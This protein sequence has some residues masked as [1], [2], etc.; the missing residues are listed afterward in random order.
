MTEKL[1]VLF[2]STVVW[3]IWEQ[4]FRLD[5]SESRQREVGGCLLRFP[6]I[7]V[8]EIEIVLTWVITSLSKSQKINFVSH[9]SKLYAVTHVPLKTIYIHQN[10]SNTPYEGAFNFIFL[11]IFVHFLKEHILWRKKLKLVMLQWVPLSIYNCFCILD[12]FLKIG[13][14]K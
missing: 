2:Y 10:P 9:L 12:Y 3:G 1:L 11:F 7:D 14:K 8:A 13:F 4:L 5:L 6:E